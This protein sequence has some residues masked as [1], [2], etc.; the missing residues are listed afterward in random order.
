MIVE[1][2]ELAGELKRLVD[3]NRREEA[4]YRAAVFLG[5]TDGR[6]I[7]ALRR[8]PLE[9]RLALFVP[10]LDS[11]VRDMGVALAEATEEQPGTTLGGDLIFHVLT[12]IYAVGGHTRV[13]ADVIN[14][15]PE[16]RHRV[17]LTD[18]Y[19]RISAKELPIPDLAAFLEGKSVETL[20]LAP[21][22]LEDRVR[23]LVGL[24]LQA[25]PA[26][27]FLYP[28]HADVIATAAVS[29]RTC[30]RSILVHHCDHLP[31]LGPTRGDYVHADVTAECHGECLKITGGTAR[32][33]G[34]TAQDYG[35]GVAKEGKD[36][37][38]AACSGPPAKFWPD[39]PGFRYV[40]LVREVMH[41]AGGRY[42]HIGGI[43]PSVLADIR[44][45][46]EAAAIESSRF[47]DVGRVE[48][49][50]QTL[51]GLDADFYVDSYPMG[52]GKTLVEA[53]GVGLPVIIPSIAGRSPLAV[54]GLNME[55]AIRWRSV[56]EIASVVNLV[57]QNRGTLS[58]RSRRD[59]DANYSQAR[60]REK[61]VELIG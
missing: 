11:L 23:Q 14:G 52:G 28:H 17:V 40:D 60:F 5:E 18:L 15:L 56:E 36:T 42:Y 29:D 13:L 1:A 47:V 30:R 22:K 59:Y 37:L 16:Y 19:G 43:P 46:L 55:S 7:A 35:A 2:N 26:A 44:S 33:L 20:V 51:K 24:L 45:H 38:D 53:L 48:S 9:A 50:W 4:L 6:M 21:A 27:C 57:R 32:Y 12:E 34:L 49:V 10:A 58:V 54:P 3:A 41:S 61:L 8:N 25:R 31:S 39:P